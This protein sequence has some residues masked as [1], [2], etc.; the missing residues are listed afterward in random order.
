MAL[1]P[2]NTARIAEISQPCP[3]GW[4]PCQRD[5]QPNGHARGPRARALA[6][7]SAWD[8]LNASL[9]AR[10]LVGQ[11]NPTLPCANAEPCDG[12]QTT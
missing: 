11:G 9:P 4:N 2:T 1:L 10:R 3:N 5:G 6:Q 12:A 7:G 8:M